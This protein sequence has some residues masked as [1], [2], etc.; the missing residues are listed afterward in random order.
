MIRL[1]DYL[2]EFLLD[3]FNKEVLENHGALNGALSGIN[4]SE[5]NELENKVFEAIK[6]NPNLT[7]KEISVNFAITFRSVPF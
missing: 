7:A 5:L 4:K 1:L 2:V 3:S 6:I